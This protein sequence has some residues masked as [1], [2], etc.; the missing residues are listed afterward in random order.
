MQKFFELEELHPKEREWTNRGG[1]G[2]GAGAVSISGTYVWTPAGDDDDGDKAA[3]AKGSKKKGVEGAT[4]KEEGEVGGEKKAA[5]MAAVA[6]EDAA[7][8]GTIPEAC[9]PYGGVLVTCLLFI[10]SG[11]V[12]AKVCCVLM[13]R[14]WQVE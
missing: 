9:R 6:G 8:E 7:G 4:Q 3:D 12:C 5:K 13:S 11:G 10:L 2:K 1:S 14:G